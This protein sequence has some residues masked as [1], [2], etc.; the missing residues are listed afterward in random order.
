M[1]SRAFLASAFA[2]ALPLGSASASAQTK[3]SPSLDL[4]GFRAS[5]DPAAGIY[6]EPAASPG[7]LEANAAA[8]LA[9]AYSPVILHDPVTKSMASRVVEH[10]LTG[11]FA[12]G[13]GL[14]GRAELGLVLP[15]AAFQSGDAPTETTAEILGNTRVAA[16]AIGDLALVGKLTLIPPTSGDHGGFALAVNERFT[17]PTGDEASFL[18]EGD[19]TSESRVLVEY[20]TRKIGFFGT[21]GIKVRPHDERFACAPAPE[22]ATAVDPCLTRIGQQMPFGLSFRLLPRRFGVDSAGRWTTFAEIYGQIPLDPIGPFAR[23]RV[24]TVEVAVG[25]RYAFTRDFSLLAGVA[26]ALVAGLGEPPFRGVLSLGW[27]PRK[28]DE[29]GDGIDDEVDQ[30]RELAEDR[31][32][33]DDDDGCPEGDNDQDSVPDQSDRCPKQ[34]EDLDGFQD[35]DGCAEPDNDGDNILDREDA[36]PNEAGPAAADPKKNG[37]GLHDRD[38]DGLLDDADSCPTAAE[39]KDNFQDADGCPDPDND[40]DG[41]VDG[42]DTC[43]NVPGVPSKDPRQRGCPEVDSDSDTFWGSEDKCPLQ[44]ED[45]NGKD[46]GDGCP[47]DAKRKPLVTVSEALGEPTLALARGIKFTKDGEIDAE[48]M[49]VIRAVGAELM[50]HPALGT[51]PAWSVA[52]GVRPTPTGGQSDAMLRA[53]A[54]VDALRK[55]TRRDTIA[56]TVGWAAVKDQGGA[57]AFG[58][59]FLILAGSPDAKK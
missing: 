59:G 4:R 49:P 25:A 23:N 39:D 33:F 21:V 8:W 15:Y 6:Y 37:C 51:K 5:P 14:Y 34:R 32:G 31:D 57:S 46:D 54:I 7:H 27:T 1:R 44:A 58:V 3:P 16:Q 19:V 50:K 18:G 35:D 9:Y 36:C 40:G 38:A 22:S 47:D 13:L 53:F 26:T 56:E 11:D 52:V 48:S 12:V 30:C 55:I 42:E 10:S 43:P 17:L 41:I 2:L 28:H 20:T 24:A 29:D 45:F